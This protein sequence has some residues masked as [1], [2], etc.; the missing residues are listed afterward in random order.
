MLILA[1][2]PHPAVATAHSH[3]DG[4][5]REAFRLVLHYSLSRLRP[6]QCE[7]GTQTDT[8]PRRRDGSLALANARRLPLPV[9][10]AAAGA[11]MPPP[12]RSLRP[13]GHADAGSAGGAAPSLGSRGPRTPSPPSTG[14]P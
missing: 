10:A 7:S 12:H 6:V 3:K 4:Q 11:D 2:W 5:V 13:R 1:N 8:I 14:T 9:C